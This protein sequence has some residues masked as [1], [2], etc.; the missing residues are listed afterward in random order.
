[1]PDPIILGCDVIMRG[2]LLLTRAGSWAVNTKH[3]SRRF[4]QIQHH[5]SPPPL[6]A[7]SWCY[8]H[9]HYTPY[10]GHFSQP[11]QSQ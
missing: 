4:A 5:S 3:H 8:N 2:Q 6:R 9:F 10:G 7:E 11:Q 1:M